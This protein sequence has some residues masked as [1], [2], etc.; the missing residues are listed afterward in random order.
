[1]QLLSLQGKRE[2]LIDRIQLVVTADHGGSTSQPLSEYVNLTACHIY[3]F[4]KR[5]R[6]VFSY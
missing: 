3:Q 4:K 5:K 2:V 6:E 1:M